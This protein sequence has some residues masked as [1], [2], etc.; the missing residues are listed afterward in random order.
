[1]VIINQTRNAVLGKEVSV[2][3]RI[4]PRIRGLLGRR[5]FRTGEAIILKPCNSIHTFFMRFPIDCLFVDK[6]YRVIKALSNIRSFRITR[7]Y[8]LSNFAVELPAGTLEFTHT[9]END[10]L[11]II[12]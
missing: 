4:F 9:Q 5:N 10:M 6:N 11:T 8:W 3:H 2:A 1:M 12:P 7:I